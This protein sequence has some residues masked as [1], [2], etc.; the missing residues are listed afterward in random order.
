MTECL[1]PNCSNTTREHVCESCQAL[2]PLQELLIVQMREKIRI[3][4]QLEMKAQKEGV[5]NAPYVTELSKMQSQ[6]E[7]YVNGRM[8]VLIDTMRGPSE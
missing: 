6:F 3:L 2:L 1:I 4:T 5:E 7:K 8:Q